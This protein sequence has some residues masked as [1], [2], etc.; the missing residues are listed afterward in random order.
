MT[1]GEI[2][3]YLMD[4]YCVVSNV[5]HVGDELAVLVDFKDQRAKSLQH[6]RKSVVYRELPNRKELFVF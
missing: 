5:K 2:M 4:G 3:I 6:F 1:L